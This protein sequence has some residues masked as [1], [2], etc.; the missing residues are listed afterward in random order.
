M[1]PNNQ[2]QARQQWQNTANNAQGHIFEGMVLAACSNYQAKGRAEIAKVPEPFR[3]TKK[4]GNAQFTGRFTAAAQP[5]FG[6]TLAGG[7]SIHFEAKYTTTDRLSR[8]VLT[9]EQMTRLERHTVLGAVT[10]VCAGI[11][12]TFVFIPW[13][14]WRDMKIIYGRQYVTAADVERYRV[15]FTG[16]VMFLDYIHPP[17]TRD[18]S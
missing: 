14:V 8:S 18:G 2:E 11:Q 4:L 1:K 6:G 16:A 7:R 9:D 15:K 12:D 3:V 10:G 5:D 13:S 17:D